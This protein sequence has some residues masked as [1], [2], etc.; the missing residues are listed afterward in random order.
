VQRRLHRLIADRKDA[1]VALTA[2]VASG[3]NIAADHRFAEVAGTVAFGPSI[4]FNRNSRTTI[5]RDLICGYA[6]TARRGGV[7]S[8]YQRGR[9]REGGHDQGG[10]PGEA[11]DRD[12]RQHGEDRREQL[13]ERQEPDAGP[14]CAASRR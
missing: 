7:R 2:S 12:D 8:P 10:R 3:F 5:R 9:R 1:V 4:T 11:A 14:D 6:L 13:Q